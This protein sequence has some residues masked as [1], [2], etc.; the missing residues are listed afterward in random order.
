MEWEKIV[1]NDAADKG[2]ISRIYKQLKQLN[3][4]KANNP[5]EK[6]AKDLNRHFSKE[7]IQM[8]N[9]HLK[10]CSTSLIIREMQVKTTMRYHLP[11]GRMAIMNKSTN[12]KHWG[13]CVEK[14]EHSCTVGGNVSWYNHCGE[15]YGV[16]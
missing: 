4:K 1:S 6:W 12:N 9:K 8:A 11:P 15:Q 13:G 14:G 16:P 5:M 7:D 10:Q 2:L 3:S